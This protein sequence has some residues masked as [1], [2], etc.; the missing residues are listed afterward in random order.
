MYKTFFAKSLL[1]E[2]S[3]IQK[4]FVLFITLYC[5]VRYLNV[6]HKTKEG[7]KPR[8]YTE[9]DVPKLSD[10]DFL[11]DHVKCLTDAWKFF[12]RFSKYVHWWSGSYKERGIV[13]EFGGWLQFGGVFPVQKA[14]VWPTPGNSV[15]SQFFFFSHIPWAWI[16]STKTARSSKEKVSTCVSL[17]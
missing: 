2:S 6:Y 12:P 9:L 4:Q 8:L 3:K 13:G 15:F 16:L 17:L 14:D 10:F 1:Q 11:P 5:N 7:P